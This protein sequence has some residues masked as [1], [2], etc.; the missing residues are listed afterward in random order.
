MKKNILITGYREGVGLSFYNQLTKLGH[1]V[2]GYDI[3]DGYDIDFK[4]AQAIILGRLDEFDI[5]INN[6][7]RPKSQTYLLKEAISKWKGKDKIIVNMNSHVVIRNNV[8]PDSPESIQVGPEYIS[9]KQEQYEYSE[10][11]NA[12]EDKLKVVNVMPT[13]VDTA[14]HKD[15]NHLTKMNPDALVSF[16]LSSINFDNLQCPKVIYI[17]ME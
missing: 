6:T 13:W 8:L 12:S 10:L 3:I 17:G 11:H 14:I 2:V 1:N 7:Y 5:F 16:V 9:E 15:L 4:P